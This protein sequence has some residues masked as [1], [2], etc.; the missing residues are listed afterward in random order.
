MNLLG[1]CTCRYDDRRSCDEIRGKR[2]DAVVIQFGLIRVVRITAIFAASSG[3]LGKWMLGLAGYQ[4]SAKSIVRPVP[5]PTVL[6]M[7]S[8]IHLSRSF[9]ALHLD[10]T[11]V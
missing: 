9:S 6:W 1:W 11:N 7:G 8:E 3:L 2:E 5:L 10:G 4:N